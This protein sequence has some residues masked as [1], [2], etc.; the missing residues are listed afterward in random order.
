MDNVFN[1]AKAS[2]SVDGQTIDLGTVTGNYSVKVLKR[3]P[4]LG[5][6]NRL[7]RAAQNLISVQGHAVKRFKRD[8]VNGTASYV[9]PNCGMRAIVVANPVAGETK[10]QGEAITSVCITSDF[11]K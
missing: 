5:K 11:Q 2:L 1:G 6:I 3:Q 10:M 7:T 8:Y 9:C 4:A